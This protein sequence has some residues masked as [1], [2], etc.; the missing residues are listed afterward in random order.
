M[1]P[2]ADTFTIIAASVSRRKIGV[3]V[4]SG[5]TAVGLRVPHVKPGVGAIAT[6]AYTNVS[7]GLEE[8]RLMRGGFSPDEVLSKLLNEDPARETRQVAIMD[9]PGRKA[10]FTG[11]MVP[12]VCGEIV[13]EDYI[14]IGN[15]LRSRLV[16][17]DM[18]AHYEQETGGFAWKLVKALEAGHRRGG[19]KRG[20]RSAAI[21]MADHWNILL[22]LR[23]DVH[24][25]PTQEL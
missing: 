2:N 20:E 15:L 16:L 8:L 1:K 7:Y 24:S 14:V 22:S 4:A 3:A 21:L 6:Q 19:D 18:A 13:G 25:N 10:V 9:F 5:S 23:V 17:K 11:S 12:G